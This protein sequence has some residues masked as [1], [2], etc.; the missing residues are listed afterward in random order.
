MPKFPQL[1]LRRQASMDLRL[2]V[3]LLEFDR[4]STNID[5]KWFEDANPY[6]PGGGGAQYFQATNNL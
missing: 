5:V 3:R 1:Y 6:I 4:F 2:L